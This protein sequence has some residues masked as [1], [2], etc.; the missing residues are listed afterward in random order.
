MLLGLFGYQ[1]K[2]KER[3]A[4]IVDLNKTDSLPY[5]FDVFEQNV[6]DDPD[7]IMLVDEK[8][9]QR[10]T[11]AEADDISGRVYAWLIKQGI[12]REDFVLICLPRGAWAVTAMIGVWKAGAD[13]V[14]LEGD[15]A[16]ERLKFIKKDCGCKAVIDLVTWQE[17]MNEQPKPCHAQTDMHDETFAVYTSG[18]TGT[19]KG[20]LHEYGNIKLNA[21][22]VKNSAIKV[23]NDRVALVAPLY[24]VASTKT[25]LNLI[26][27]T[28]RLYILPYSTA[29]N[30][31][32]LKKYYRDN[33]ITGTFFSPSMIRALGGDI[34]PYLKIIHTGSEPANGISVPGVTLVNNYS[35]SESAFTLTQFIIDKSYDAGLQKWIRIP[36]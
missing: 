9:K 7:C 2:R 25:V 3:R 15:H 6:Q 14:I 35:M 33:K 30:P 4:N 1:I 19:P 16:G 10:M 5:F 20:V 26:Y 36:K 17:I 23:K 12:G 24:F 8:H 11:R 34:S 13:L 21:L 32:K 28:H 22:S 31:V 29:K 27:G 18:S